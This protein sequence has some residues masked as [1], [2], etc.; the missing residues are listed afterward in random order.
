MMHREGS[1]VSAY[2]VGRV[3]AIVS[4]LS[5]CLVL[6]GTGS[7]RELDLQVPWRR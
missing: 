6:S 1:D 7:C 2:L 4:M 5:R 3:R